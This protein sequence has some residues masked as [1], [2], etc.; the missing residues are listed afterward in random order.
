MVRRGRERE[1]D[2]EDGEEGEGRMEGIGW[3]VYFT[4]SSTHFPSPTAS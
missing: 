2:G 1:D 4:G 3:G